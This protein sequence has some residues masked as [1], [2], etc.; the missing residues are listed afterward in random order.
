[1]SE[2]P[3]LTVISALLLKR[4]LAFIPFTGVRVSASEPC[5]V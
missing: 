1:M 4:V 5:S 2:N 3:L